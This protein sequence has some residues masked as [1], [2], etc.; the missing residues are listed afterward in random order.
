MSTEQ[1]FLATQSVTAS[2]AGATRLW[3]FTWDTDIF[4]IFTHSEMSVYIP[5]LV[6]FPVMF[7]SSQTKDL[8]WPQAVNLYLTVHLVILPSKQNDQEGAL[9]WLL[10]T[11]RISLHHTLWGCPRKG[12]VLQPCTFTQCLH[13]MLS[14]YKQGPSFLPASSNME[15]HVRPQVQAG[16]GKVVQQEW[17]L[18]KS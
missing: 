14:C 8:L 11:G 10:P 3:A 17:D 16:R 18:R 5:L 9:L 4:M 2:C 15:L 12:T 1:V 7:L 6:S 13:S